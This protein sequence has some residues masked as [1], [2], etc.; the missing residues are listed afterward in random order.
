M[1]VIVFYE[2]SKKELSEKNGPVNLM[3]INEFT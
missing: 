3:T 1:L 2:K